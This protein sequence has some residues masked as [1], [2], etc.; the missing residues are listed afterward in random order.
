[1]SAEPLRCEFY[2]LTLFPEVFE[3]VLKRGL[4][5]KALK[6]GIVSYLP[7]PMRAFAQNSHQ[8]V[9]SPPYGGGEG[10]VLRADVLYEAWKSVFHQPSSLDNEPLTILL[11]PQGEKL[12]QALA[13]EL[14]SYHRFI[15]VCGQYEGV[16]ERFVQICVNREISIGDYI[17][18]GGEVAALVFTEVITRLISGVVGNPDSLK[19][20]SFEQSGLLK[21][22]QYTR[23]QVFLG[24]EVPS[25]L[26]SGN[27]QWIQAWR[28]NQM[29]E[30]TRVK[31]P[32][33]WEL[34]K[35]SLDE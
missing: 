16:D 32:D 25:V 29:Q 20:E 27:H 2:F 26:L 4:L 23:P 30:R 28:K 6:R 21:Y 18:L 14:S 9:D 7:I 3:T 31:R 1:M 11:S 8:T 34:W 15:L 22:P 13:W 5:G 17:L 12:T 24:K 35:Q 19:N 10:M 33:L